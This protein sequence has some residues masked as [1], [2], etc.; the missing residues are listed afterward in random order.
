MELLAPLIL[1]AISMMSLGIERET[2]ITCRFI[3]ALD[4]LMKIENNNL[5]QLWMVAPIAMI[6]RS[7][8]PHIIILQ[9]V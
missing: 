8:N 5:G 1:L 4:I 3:I 6:I 7:I 2:S 9:I